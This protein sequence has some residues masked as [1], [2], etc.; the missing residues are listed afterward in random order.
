MRSNHSIA[1]SRG[2]WVFWRVYHVVAREKSG[3]RKGSMSSPAC[4]VSE[5]GRC[6]VF[7]PKAHKG[8]GIPLWPLE[9]KS[10]DCNDA[11]PQLNPLQ[12]KGRGR[13]REQKKRPYGRLC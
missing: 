12:M 10:D 8:K 11:G 9:A 2:G 7:A 13:L 6:G 3:G 4:P 1:S 5:V